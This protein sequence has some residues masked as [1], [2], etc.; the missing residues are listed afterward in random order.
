MLSLA[1]LKLVFGL[2]AVCICA[3]CPQYA[4][5]TAPNPIRRVREPQTRNN[6]FVYVPSH[7]P[8]ARPR[9]L[10]VLCHGT[11]PWDSSLRQIRDWV[12]LAEAQNFIVIAPNL[13]GTRGDFPPPAQRQ[14][15]K[16]RDDEKTILAAVRHVSGG[17]NIDPAQIFLT[18]WSAGNYAV[19]H[20]GLRHPE[21]FRA[22]AVMQGNFDAAFMADAVHHI[23]RHQPVFVVY[24]SVDVLTRGQT[25]TCVD[26]L[27][28]KDAYVFDDEIA[29]PHRSHPKVAYEFFER[30]VKDVPWL[31]LRAFAPDANDPY[32]VQF[33][34]RAS[35]RLPGYR[36]TFAEGQTSSSSEPVFKFEEGTHAVKLE[37]RL[38]N[39]KAIIRSIRVRVP[40]SR[41]PKEIDR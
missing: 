11:R 14:I 19:L 12:K 39:G 40:Q 31:T 2:L 15:Q 36:W 16:Q 13:K 4:D 24:G 8:T 26:W 41:F 7:E 34:T 22:L 9:P 37:T 29:G 18:G 33:K 17:N 30:I 35:F 38:P 3:G 25:R 6:Y 27:Y 5:P 23:D 28:E 20:T 21:I 1:R 10:I 32:T